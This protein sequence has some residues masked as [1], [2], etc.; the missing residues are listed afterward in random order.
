ML[1]NYRLYLYF[2]SFSINVLFCPSIQSRISH[3]IELSWLP[4]VL[5]TIIVPQFFLT[6]KVLK[7]T[8]HAFFR[9][10]L[11]WGLP[12]LS[13]D[14]TK[15]MNFLAEFTDVKC[16]FIASHQEVHDITPIWMNKLQ[17]QS[18]VQMNLTKE[19][20]LHYVI[21]NGWFRKTEPVYAIR[22]QDTD[23]PCRSGD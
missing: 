19:D 5:Q 22:N 18:T 10:L 1:L 14:Y 23:D 16:P 12:K 15:V 6:L 17:L 9:K 2:T 20:A 11:I 21:H 13:C 8:A 4:S 7:N 3:G